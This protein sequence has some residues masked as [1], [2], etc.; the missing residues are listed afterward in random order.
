MG[1]T[2]ALLKQGCDPAQILVRLSLRKAL[3][4]CESVLDIG[5]GATPT[6]RQLGISRIAGLEGYR[7]SFEEA[8][9]RNTHDE[10]VFGDVRDLS[11]HFRSGQ[12]DGCVALDLIEHLSKQDGLKLIQEMEKVA[13]KRI[14]LFTPSGFLPQKQAAND[15]LEEHLSGWE[16]H[17]MRR[18]GF[19][20]I[21]LLGP[22]RLRGEYH[23]I[24][25]RPRIFWSVV[26]LLEHFLWTRSHPSQA[27][28]I[29]CVKR[30]SGAQ[31]S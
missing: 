9:R 12:F 26:S 6:M 1:L 31:T 4:G 14:V 23:V 7:P 29:L 21:G 3:M 24:K 28:A 5:C 17:E 22:K 18:L 10:L 8:R 27:A 11:K 20:V 15:D 2:L 25:G 19:D 16:T 13:R 30:I